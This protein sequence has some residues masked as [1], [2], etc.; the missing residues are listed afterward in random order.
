MADE[1]KK[2]VSVAVQVTAEELRERVMQSLVDVGERTYCDEDGE[3]IV[4]G[5]GGLLTTVTVEVVKDV[6]KQFAKRIEEEVQTAIKEAVKAQLDSGLFT[7]GQY[8]GRTDPKSL[9]QIIQE[10]LSAKSSRGYQMPERTMAMHVI[11]D[12]VENALKG[13]LAAELKQLKEAFA[14]QVKAKLSAAAGEAISR[15][16]GIF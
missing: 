12:A 14:S 7:V 10:Q 8:G 9:N 4:A 3:E 6:K 5:I 11:T 16:M 2:V 15:A 1:T 13:E